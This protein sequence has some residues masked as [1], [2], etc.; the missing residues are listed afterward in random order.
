M[1]YWGI[2]GGHC[3]DIFGKVSM[4]QKLC[5]IAMLAVLGWFFTVRGVTNTPGI[6][7]TQ[8]FEGFKSQ[9]ECEVAKAAYTDYLESM[10]ANIEV[11]KCQVRVGA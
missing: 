4:K 10:G 11:S 7:L 2:N 1:D 8:E 6:W 3:Y 9:M 5:N